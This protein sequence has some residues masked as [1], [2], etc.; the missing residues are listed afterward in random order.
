MLIFR[1]LVPLWYLSFD[2]LNFFLNTTKPSIG[3]LY[4]RAVKMLQ[5]IYYRITVYCSGQDFYY[6]TQ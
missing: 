4:V 6:Y 2:F 5:D 1:A 3:G